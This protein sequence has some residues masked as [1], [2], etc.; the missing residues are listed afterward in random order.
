MTAVGCRNSS[1]SAQGSP[2]NTR[3]RTSVKPTVQSLKLAIS[4][5][6]RRISMAIEG[7]IWWK[8]TSMQS[9]APPARRRR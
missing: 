6:P 9:V 8:T 1:G 5:T 2:A 7:S 4:W 3:R